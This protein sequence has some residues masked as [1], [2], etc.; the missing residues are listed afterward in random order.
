VELAVLG[1]NLLH[2]THVEFDE[3][4]LPAMIPRAAYF[5]ARIRF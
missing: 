5:Q 4:G 3:H 1:S 2:R